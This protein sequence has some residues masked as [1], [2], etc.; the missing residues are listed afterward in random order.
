MTNSGPVGTSTY[1]GNKGKGVP[2]D[3]HGLKAPSKEG[4]PEYEKQ[5]EDSIILCEAVKRMRDNDVFN[6]EAFSRDESHSGGWPEEVKEILF[7]H[8][9]LKTEKKLGLEYI[10]IHGNKEIAYFETLKDSIPLL[11]HN[12]GFSSWREISYFVIDDDPVE[13]QVGF[14]KWMKRIGKTPKVN[15]GI[16]H[17]NWGK[18]GDWERML[19][20]I[21]RKVF[22]AKW[23]HAQRRIAKYLSDKVAPY[24][25]R[26]RNLI[27]ERFCVIDYDEHPTYPAGHGG[28]S[29]GCAKYT[30][31]Y[32]G[33]EGMVLETFVLF[34][35]EI[36]AHARSGLLVHKLEDNLASFFFAYPR[37]Y[38]QFKDPLY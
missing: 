35:A 4:T 28:N 10:D 15:K 33:L 7:K 31:K 12:L 9:P 18:W 29:A 17:G 32:Y 11:M 30:V 27:G 34:A 26:D 23:K 21:E 24:S 3:A 1:L 5:V 6:L 13:L 14:H 25:S 22:G 36:S 19:N 16:I 37:K 20:E 2:V 38:S 8:T